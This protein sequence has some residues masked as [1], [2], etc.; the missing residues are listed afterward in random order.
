MGHL[1][2]LSGA[3]CDFHFC[4]APYALR[5]PA[6]KAPAD[7]PNITFQVGL[8]RTLSQNLLLHK[9]A[10]KQL[11]RSLWRFQRWAQS[12]TSVGRMMIQI[13]PADNRTQT[14]KQ[15]PLGG[16]SVSSWDQVPPKMKMLEVTAN[17]N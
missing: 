10:P 9:Q 6:M 14:P 2:D 7:R 17:H 1:Q 8:K 16:E 11:Q 13:A 15:E 12:L 4:C 3:L 5:R